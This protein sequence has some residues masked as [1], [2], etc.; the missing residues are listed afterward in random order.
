VKI[1]EK[2]RLAFTTALAH[3][4]QSINRLMAAVDPQDLN[5]LDQVC[6]RLRQGSF[7]PNVS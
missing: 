6:T 1:T 2:G 5:Q 3:C 7:Q 4:L